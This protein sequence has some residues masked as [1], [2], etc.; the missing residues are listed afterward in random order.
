MFTS[1]SNIRVLCSAI[2]TEIEHGIELLDTHRLVQYLCD[3]TYYVIAITSNQTCGLCAIGKQASMHTLSLLHCA[4]SRF[5]YQLASTTRW[6]YWKI[7]KCACNPLNHQTTHRDHT[8]SY[9]STCVTKLHAEMP[10]RNPTATMAIVLLA[11]NSV[12]SFDRDL[13]RDD[14]VQ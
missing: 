10:S 12:W 8:E 5:T 13:M 14:V 7:D 11:S 9:G 2:Q 6:Y 1:Y 3:I 4:H